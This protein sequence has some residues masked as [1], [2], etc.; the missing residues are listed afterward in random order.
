MI[1][2]YK[3]AVPLLDIVTFSAPAGAKLLRVEP[4]GANICVWALVDTDEPDVLRHVRIAGTG[5]PITHPHPLYINT[6]EMMDGALVFHAFEVF[7]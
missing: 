2:V 7:E 3:Y 4:Q 6:F 5:H 1:A